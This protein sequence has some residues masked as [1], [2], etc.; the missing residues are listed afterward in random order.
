MIIAVPKE[1][2]DSE[3]RVAATP[4]T[5]QHFVRMGLEICVETGAGTASGFTDDDY[6]EAGAAVSD[7]RSIYQK[8][9][10]LLKIHAPQTTELPLLQR[11]QIILAD[12]SGTSSLRPFAEKKTTCFALEQIPRISRAQTMDI[13]TS[14][15]NLAGYKA[16]INAAAM[17]KK[18]M[19]LMMTAAGTLPPAKVLILGAGVAGLQAIATAKRLGAQVFASDIRPET[20]EQINSLGAKF[21]NAQDIPA[22][23]AKTD[24]LITTALAP[25]KPAPKLVSREMLA[26]MPRGGVI[27]DMA[28]AAG[29]NVEG[30]EDNRTISRGGL[31][32]V[33]AGNLA[34]KL[35]DS[36]SRMFAQNIYNFLS[37]WYNSETRGFNFDF[38]DEIIAK[39]CVVHNGRIINREEN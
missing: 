31:T 34:T 1:T 36:A 4:E 26:Q 39:T 16:V 38:A 21:V 10:I 9:N 15:S 35:P 33:G 22:Q 2:L 29:G 7:T 12:F 32:L 18:T 6:R 14:Q 5:A 8:A 27:I 11:G 17:L 13:L 19:P 24:I 3:T 28:A 37:P 20:Q 23:L 30:T 25:G